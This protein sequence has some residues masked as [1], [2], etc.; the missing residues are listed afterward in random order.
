[1]VLTQ[2]EFLKGWELTM[3][4]FTLRLP[5][6]LHQRLKQIAETRDFSVNKLFEEVATLIRAEQDVRTRHELRRKRGSREGLLEA[7]EKLDRKT[8]KTKLTED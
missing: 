3:A 4:N 5:D 6:N 7:L 1:V 2:G 8:K